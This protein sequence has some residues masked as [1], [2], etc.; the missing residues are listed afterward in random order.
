MNF[1]G[2]DIGKVVLLFLFILA[3]T[4]CG[5]MKPP[6]LYSATVFPLHKE[7][8]GIRVSIDPLTD[9][10]ESK[11]YFGIDLISEGILPVYIQV[12]NNASKLS[13]FVDQN[14]FS[15]Q[16][17]S[18]NSLH[19]ESEKI[20]SDKGPGSSAG[21]AILLL[22][23][24]G[25]LPV[26]MLSGGKM[27]SDATVINYGFNLQKLHPSTVSPNTS[28]SGFI[29]F[30]LPE[31]GTIPNNWRLVSSINSISGEKITEIV[32]LSTD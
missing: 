12:A 9:K 10:E 30:Q 17:G 7:S 19:N 16:T 6:P 2:F 11:T 24:M 4:G 32:F 15:L 29:Y 31:K 23:P 5:T 18:E 25:L 26:M 13:L 8:D 21:T 1:K 20:K 3:T 22:S 14:T 28:I 27:L